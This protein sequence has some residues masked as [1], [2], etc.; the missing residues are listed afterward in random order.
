MGIITLFAYFVC[1]QYFQRSPGSTRC[2]RATSKAALSWSPL[3]PHDLE[4]AHKW[5][6]SIVIE[7]IND[8]L[9]AKAVSD[10]SFRKI[11]LA[12]T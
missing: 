9:E 10:F 6:S 11:T 12:S 4:L 2:S 5:C 3:I 1:F 8:A 7:L